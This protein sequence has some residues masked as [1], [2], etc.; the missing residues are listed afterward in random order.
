MSAKLRVRFSGATEY[1]QYFPDEIPECFES[2]LDI[3][4]IE[5]VYETLGQD[6]VANLIL[7]YVFENVYQIYV[8]NQNFARVHYHGDNLLRDIKSDT[9]YMCMHESYV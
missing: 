9:L 6:G 7:A 3:A 4:E 8:I 2:D 1:Q 5:N